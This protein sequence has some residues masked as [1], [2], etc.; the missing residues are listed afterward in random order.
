M[1][2][3]EAPLEAA[4]VAG[5][6]ASMTGPPERVMPSMQAPPRRPTGVVAAVAAARMGVEVA[7]AVALVRG[8]K[9]VLVG[10]STIARTVP[11][12]GEDLSLSDP[13]VEASFQ[14]IQW[15]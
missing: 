11:D 14:C 3:A 6:V 10:D 15:R 4:L 1:A 13:P 12:A 8:R 2:V 7:V 5:V 9:V